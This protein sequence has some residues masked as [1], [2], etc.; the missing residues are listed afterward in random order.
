MRGGGVPNCPCCS[1]P[2]GE[3][4]V[5][6]FDE[7]FWA[8]GR[9]CSGHYVVVPGLEDCNL[10]LRRG[11]VAVCLSGREVVV[12]GAEAGDAEG[13]VAGW[14]ARLFPLFPVVQVRW[15]VVLR[16]GLSWAYGPSACDVGVG[17]ICQGLA[18]FDGGDPDV[19]A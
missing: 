1:G 12:W 7:P 5:C 17:V 16:W 4:A 10:D 19:L 15:V 14:C 2:W 3:H 8:G 9:C 11:V 13:G 6:L 18:P